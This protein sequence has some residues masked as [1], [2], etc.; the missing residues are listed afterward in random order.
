RRA[1]GAAVDVRLLRESRRDVVESVVDAA[2][3][4]RERRL[5]DEGDVVLGDELAALEPVVVET[6]VGGVAI[7]D[8]L[9]GARVG[10]PEEVLRLHVAGHLQVAEAQ[11]GARMPRG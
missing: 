10:S 4:D 2:P 1:I 8:E 3:E 9:P 7:L 5:L 6:E 11:G